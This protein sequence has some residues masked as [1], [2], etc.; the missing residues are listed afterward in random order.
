[1]GMDCSIFFLWIAN[2][3]AVVG[4]GLFRSQVIEFHDF[5]RDRQESDEKV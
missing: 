3:S 4:A 5:Y 2:S 1:M